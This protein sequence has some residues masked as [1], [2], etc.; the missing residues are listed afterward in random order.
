MSMGNWPGG[1]PP[2]GYDCFSLISLKSLCWFGFD[3]V[4]LF[5]VSRYMAPLQGVVSMEGGPVAPPHI[6]VTIFL[7]VL[8]W[9]ND[10]GLWW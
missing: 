3:G 8:L 4:S 5:S 2:V 9:S 10:D 7:L 6:Q 1:L